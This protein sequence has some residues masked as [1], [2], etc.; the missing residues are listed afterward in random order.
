[1]SQDIQT[2]KLL[3]SSL[4]LENVSQ[5]LPYSKGRASGL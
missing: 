3:L 2:L 1:M 4:F 5:S